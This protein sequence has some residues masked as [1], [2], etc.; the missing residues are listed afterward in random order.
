MFLMLFSHGVFASSL[1]V[2][3]MVVFSSSGGEKSCLFAAFREEL[4][5]LSLWHLGIHYSPSFSILTVDL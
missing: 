2:T 4:G 3:R 1:P 5:H